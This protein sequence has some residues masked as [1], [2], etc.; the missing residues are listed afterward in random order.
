MCYFTRAG[1]PLF[2]GKKEEKI[3][4]E[5]GETKRKGPVLPNKREGMSVEKLTE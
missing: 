4:G 2:W 1:N 5:R 3:I